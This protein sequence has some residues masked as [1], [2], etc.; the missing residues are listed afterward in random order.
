LLKGLLSTPNMFTAAEEFADLCEF[1]VE[2][3]AEYVLTNPLSAFGRGAKSQT[4]LAADA[5]QMRAIRAV[6]A[7]FADRLDLVRI[8]FPNDELLPLGGCDAGRLLYVFTDGDVAAC[9]YL[10]FAARTDAS[11]YP[12]GE[13]VVGNI[14]D[15][16][17]AGLLDEYDFHDRY[18]VG[19][20][21]TCG[22]CAMSS[23]CG[24]GCPAAVVSRGGRIGDLDS[25]Q[26]PVAP[27]PGWA[28]LPLVG[29]AR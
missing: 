3:G 17:V 24:K 22:S 26:C 14:L 2:V 20:N 23:A 28:P 12:R 21:S 13:F 9:P 6:T 10:E 19:T 1:A 7:R 15:G 16:P 27:A 25:E 18:Q 4:R 11:A 29:A 8:R 5:A